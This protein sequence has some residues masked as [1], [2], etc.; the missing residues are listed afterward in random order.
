ME[1][2]IMI[3]I[4]SMLILAFMELGCSAP[5]D[6]GS[7][8]AVR[9]GSDRGRGLEAYPLNSDDDA[10]DFGTILARNQV[11]RH[12]FTLANPTT[13]PNGTKLRRKALLSDGL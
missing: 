7:P 11:L 6:P 3:K 10:F 2:R 12:E 9:G 4:L 5:D 13:V 8:A 1:T